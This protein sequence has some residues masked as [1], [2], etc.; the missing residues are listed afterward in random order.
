MKKKA[1]TIEHQ[2]FLN[3]RTRSKVI[4]LACQL[5]LLVLFLG[6][7]ELL[8]AYEVIDS[9]ITSSPSRIWATFIDLAK[10]DLWRH[11]LTTLAE[12][13]VEPCFLQSGI[14]ISRRTG[15]RHSIR[16]TDRNRN[17]SVI[18]DLD[19]R[20]FSLCGKGCIPAKTETDASITVPCK[21]RIIAGRQADE[22]QDGNQFC[23][24]ILN[25]SLVLSGLL[26]C[27]N[28]EGQ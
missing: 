18:T 15:Y 13:V 7:W 27:W 26:L 12:T 16:I 24:Y 1:L 10:G 17:L 3:R 8:A 5:G 9:F 6:L 2:R 19:S 28:M 25:H 23:M 14:G 11:A 20:A 21:H 22:G 4:V